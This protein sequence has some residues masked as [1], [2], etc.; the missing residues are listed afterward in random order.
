MEI[1]IVRHCE[2]DYAKDSLTENGR[3]TVE[4]ASYTD[5]FRLLIGIKSKHIKTVCSNIM[6]GTAE[7][8]QPEECQRKLHP[9]L[10]L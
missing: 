9:H 1:L 7:C 8:H 6:R 3:Q 4:R 5:K 2:P 10:G